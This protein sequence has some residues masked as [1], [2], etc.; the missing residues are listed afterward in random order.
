MTETYQPG[1]IVRINP[2]ELHCND[3]AFIDEI[4]ASGSRK[5]NK[6]THTMRSLVWPISE[7]GFG[8][9]DHNHH[10]MRRAPMAKHFSRAQMLRFEPEVHSQL[11][12]LCDKLLRETP[13]R[14]FDI[15]MAYSCFT[16]D[17]ISG[18]SFGEPL[19]LLMQDG[20]EPNWRQATYAFLDTTFMF[21]YFPIMKRLTVVGNFFARRGWLGPDVAMLTKAMF[22]R[23]PGLIGKTWS[24]HA[25]G[26]QRERDALYL[27]M[28]ESKVLPEGE[29]TM[30]RMAGEGMAL[31]NAGTETTSWTLSVITFYLLSQPELMRRLTEELRGAV[32]DAKQLSWPV[33]E[34]LGYLNG[35]VMEGLRLSYGVSARSP[36]VA[37]DE[38]LVYRG[39]GDGANGKQ[40][41]YVI[42]RGWAVGMSSVLVHHDEAVFPDSDQF[43]PERWLDGE[44]RP[45]RDLE[46]YLL[47][48]SRGSRAC[49]GMILAQSELFLAVA[50]LTLRVFPRMQL[51]ETTVEDVRYDYDKFVP[52]ARPGSKGVRVT[53]S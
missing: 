30:M 1:P 3:P 47:S 19:G 43:R 33:L 37:T 51:Y 34:K 50:A 7:T 25:A 48:F 38:D 2:F 24:D 4:Y 11:Q 20:W 23:L 22:E 6:S 42:P 49:L 12:Y 18:Y 13:G 41:E 29:K 15:T 27:D 46:K 44:G 9:I 35:V 17:V 39:G 40:F 32:A 45:R 28:L 26:I 31:M 10:R 53:I 5:R 8:T 16:S 36:R 52:V 21:R 14:P